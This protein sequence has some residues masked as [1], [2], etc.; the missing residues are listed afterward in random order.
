MPNA[1]P[2]IRNL[3]FRLS[4]FPIVMFL[5]LGVACSKGEKEKAPVVSV[6]AAP[7]RQGEIQRVIRADAVL[8]AIQQSAIT[9]K[10]SSPVKKFYVNR[11][12]KVKQG[13]M[14]AVLENPGP[15]RI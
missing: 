15:G 7:V 4:V 5:L 13:Q 1:A 2:H 9:P 14:L 3:P 10:I 6:Q 11:G 12:S 8:F